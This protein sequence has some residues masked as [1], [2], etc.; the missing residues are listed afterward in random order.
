MYWGWLG[1]LILMQA[2]QAVAR[3]E[4]T[5][6]NTLAGFLGRF[7]PTLRTRASAPAPAALGRRL[8]QATNYLVQAGKQLCPL[9]RAAT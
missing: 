6:D 3:G 2:M 9:P 8:Q 4:A 1:C 7:N 5:L